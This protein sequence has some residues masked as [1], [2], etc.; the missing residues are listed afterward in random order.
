MGTENV[1]GERKQEWEQEREWEQELLAE[2]IFF[3][4]L[5]NLFLHNEN[6]YM[7]NFCFQNR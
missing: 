5:S 2:I 4:N 6:F 7:N 3:F 1:N